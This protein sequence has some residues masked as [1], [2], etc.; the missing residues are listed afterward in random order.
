MP[1]IV[2]HLKASDLPRRLSGRH[3]EF[4]RILGDLMEG[5]TIR[6]ESRQRDGDIRIDTR[7]LGDNRFDDGNLHIIDD[8]SSNAVNVLNAGAAYFWRVWQVDPQGVKAFSSTG[9]AHYDP[10]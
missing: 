4:Y 1:K 8:R 7:T 6:V 9:A 2:L 10:D 3:L 5:Q